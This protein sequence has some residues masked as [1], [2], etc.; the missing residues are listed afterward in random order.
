MANPP[1]HQRPPASPLQL[2]RPHAEVRQAIVRRLEIGRQLLE[3]TGVGDS[4]GQASAEAEYKK[5]SAYNADL[6]IQLFTSPRFA[7]EYRSAGN[8]AVHPRAFT[9]ADRLKRIRTSLV[10][11]AQALDSILDRL[12]LFP[13]VLQPESERRGAANNASATD[14]VFIVHGHD[15]QA[16]EAVAR[17]VERL[18]LAAI[19][20]HEKATGG[21]TIIEKLEHYS[22]VGFAVVLLTPDDVGAAKA[23]K[24]AD[25]LQFRAR[26]NVVLELG[27]FVG[28]LGRGRVCA[29][30]RGPLELPSDYVG[31][32]YVP[33]DGGGWKLELARELKE[34]G[35]EIDM[36]RA[37]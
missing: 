17:F 24:N 4:P 33:M 16:L 14:K 6:L 3:H 12:D 29:L 15:G 31:V 20:L 18:G 19:V 13:F 34:A 25:S 11:E 37:M 26:Q 10:R 21:R 8:V 7:N 36:N 30:Y 27:Y 23:E 5:W 1:D 2:R 32:G 22:E 35:F 28:R 9:T